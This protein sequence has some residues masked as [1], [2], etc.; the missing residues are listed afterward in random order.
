MHM[1]SVGDIR[2]HGSAQLDDIPSGGLA[3]GGGASPL[4]QISPG[5]NPLRIP[6]TSSQHYQKHRHSHRFC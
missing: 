4:P 1:S 6:S 3:L 5:H 2:R